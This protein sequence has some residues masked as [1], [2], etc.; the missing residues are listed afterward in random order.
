M[1]RIKRAVALP[2]RILRHAEHSKIDEK[3]MARNYYDRLGRL[4]GYSKS[5]KEEAKENVGILILIAVCLIFYP[6]W[7]AASHGYLYL[8]SVGIHPV[9]SG[10]SVGIPAVAFFIG[11]IAS[12]NVRLAYF[13]SLTVFCAIRVFSSTKD[14]SDVIW[15]STYAVIVIAVGATITYFLSARISNE[16]ENAEQ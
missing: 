2:N 16:V 4:R 15:A 9:F 6:V 7:W 12:S 8:R 13:G 3:K 14:N 10:I 11:L 5:S 1:I